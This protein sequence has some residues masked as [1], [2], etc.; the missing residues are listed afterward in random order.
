MILVMGPVDEL[1][2][3]F[4]LSH[5]TATGREYL[6]VDERHLGAEVRLELDW[7]P[8]P[9]GPG[10]LTGSVCFPTWR[11]GLE[12]LSGIYSRLGTGG[13]E[14]SQT[15]EARA[16]RAHA[17]ALLDLFPGPVANRMTAMMSN[18]SKPCQYAAILAAGLRVPDTLAGADWTR[19][20]AFARGLDGDPII[21]SVSDERSLVKQV[22][23]QETR[24]AARPGHPLPP[25]QF[26]QRIPGANVRVHVVGASEVLACRA[27]TQALDYRHPDAT[28]H[29]VSLHAV[30]LPQPVADACR[31]LSRALG[32]D[33]SGIDLIEPPGGSSDPGDWVCLEVNT[34]PGFMWFEQHAGLPIAGALAAFL[35]AP[36]R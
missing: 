17:A 1:L 16:E 3:A 5:L 20:E 29:T 15:P 10:R 33:L 24:A 25:H 6:F 19:W 27:E 35:H 21:K 12:S 30:T 13:L 26:Q 11:V 22:S 18:G 7:H 9:P 23:W 4:F 2:T 31:R 8:G 34:S 32:L 28:G 36:L 14:L